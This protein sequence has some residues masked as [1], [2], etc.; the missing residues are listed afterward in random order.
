[1]KASIWL[2]RD[3]FEIKEV[4]IPN[5]DN[6]QVLVKVKKVGLCGTDVHITQGL[7]PQTPPKILGHEFSGEIV[8]VGKNVNNINIGKRVACNTTSSCGECYNCKN[9]QIS[10][11]SNQVASSGAFAEFSNMPLSSAIEIPEN[12]SFE[13]AA[14]TEPAS[15]CISGIEMIEYKKD[16]KVLIFGSGIMGMLCLLFVKEKNINYVV[17]SEPNP[18]RR[19]M[20]LKMG[21]DFVIDPM[22]KNYKKEIEEL[23]GDSGYDIFIEAVGNPNL[24]AEGI[25]N[26]KPRGQALMIGVHPK[27][28]NLQHDLY[29]LHYK[30]IKLFGAF[31]RGDYFSSVPKRIEKFGLDKLV[32]KTFKLEE[33]NKAIE[34]TAKGSGMKYMISP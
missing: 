17:V 14:M 19:K 2:G 18:S 33:I 24:L 15:C 16:S 22:S 4:P 21:A 10:R 3:K 34:L 30:E 12:M 5:L 11:C 7:F 13:V 23:S 26:L 8:D 25:S 31:G 1:M 29:D 27:N 20:A 6:D 9:W 32:T 28:S